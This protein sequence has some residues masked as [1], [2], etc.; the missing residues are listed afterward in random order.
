MYKVALF[1]LDGTLINTEHK[2]REAWARLFR[3]HRVPYDDSVLRSFTGRPAKEA[4]ADHVASFAGYGIDELCAE[5]AAYAALPD[6]PAAVTVD[7]A[8][9]LLHR[10]Q[11]MRVPL[12][13]VTSG[14][15]DYAESALMT[16]GV[17]QLLDVLI[18]ADDV[19]RGKPDPEGYSTACSALNVEPSEAVVFEDAPAGILAAKRAGIFCVGLTTTHEAEALTE[20]DV[21][22][23]DLTDVCWPYI[24][25]P[26]D[27]NH[28]VT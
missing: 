22:I 16:L 20:A 11:Q 26:S 19:S 9:E 18:T 25:P 23:K 8:M 2:N 12:G 21:V 3:R 10:L 4:M 1:D 5:A 14:P 6:M 13:V 17:L 24:V 27:S 15:R 7:G 28:D